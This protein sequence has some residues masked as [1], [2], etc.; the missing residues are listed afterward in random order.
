VPE[1]ASSRIGYA[2][3]GR[4][5]DAFWTGNGY[6]KDAAMWTP[7]FRAAK[8]F[9]ARI[10]CAALDSAASHLAKLRAAGWTALIV[11]TAPLPP[12]DVPPAAKRRRPG[13]KANENRRCRD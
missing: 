12:P 6:A 2:I 7:D 10:P 1:S 5:E 3:Y 4:S 13:A 9:T 8:V 11:A